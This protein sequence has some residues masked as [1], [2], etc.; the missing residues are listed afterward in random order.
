[1]TRIIACVSGKGG[2]GKT[3]LVANLGTALTKLGKKV[4]VLDANV[5]TPNLGLHLGVPFY[6]VTLHDVLKGKAKIEDAM[7]VHESG[8]RV[9]PAG[10][11][12]KDLRGADPRNLPSALLDLLGDAD[13][14][15][16]DVAAGLGREALSA[17]EAAD[18][19]ILITNPEVTSVTDALKAMK[20][21]QQLG[22]NMTGVVIN[23]T[24]GRKHEMKT[25]DVI[26]MLGN[27]ELLATIP[28]DI[29][30]QRSIAERVPVVHH[31][32]GSPASKAMM[33]L[34]ARIAGEEAGYFSRE[35]WYRK[36]FSFIR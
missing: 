27:Y 10:I 32:P 35:P 26:S 4:I 12:L 11:S 22:T 6:P 34:A 17:M 13:I 3:T 5:T 2:V 14:V 25:E 18:E 28:E 36:V 7:Y 19:M 33:R 15:L 29:N 1:M 16:L 23:K 9:V 8:L 24:T 31:S 21:A 30:V 20:L